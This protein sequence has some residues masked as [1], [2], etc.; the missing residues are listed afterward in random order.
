VIVTTELFGEVVGITLDENGDYLI[1]DEGKDTIWR[2]R[3]STPDAVTMYPVSVGD[4]IESLRGIAVDSNRSVVVSN[5]GTKQLLRIDPNSGV[6]TVVPPDVAYSAIQGIALDRIP[7]FDPDGDGVLNSVDNC[8]TLANPDQLDLDGDGFGD[9]CDNDDDADGVSDVT[10]NCR[11]VANA[12]Q[13]DANRDGYGNLC[14][15]D[16]DDDGAVGVND[17]GLF[18][19]NYGHAVP[20]PD[21]QNLA[22]FDL[23][24]D[25]IIGVP[26]FGLFRALYG[27]PPGPSG[28]ACRGIIPCP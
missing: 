20:N 27:R 1:P 18:H 28:L 24:S 15:P 5:Q 16:F 14:D 19:P 21:P 9:V 8:P 11:M 6:Q 7:N 4:K 25:G 17:F 22:K 13:K 3:A 2:Y 26:D 12:N 10:D 23:N